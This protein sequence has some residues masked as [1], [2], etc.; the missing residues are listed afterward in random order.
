MQKQ[1]ADA[2]RRRAVAQI[3]ARDAFGRRRDERPVAFGVFVCGVGPVGNQREVQ[4]A[5]R[6]REVMDLEP[7]DLLVY[8]LHGSQQ[9]RHRD[10][11]AQVRG[12]PVAQ[13]ESRAA[14]SPRS[15]G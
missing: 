13:L 2:A 7:F 9:R 5:F 1:K 12:N 8:R 3:E 6:T 4:I 14:A 10:K 15:Q 11:R